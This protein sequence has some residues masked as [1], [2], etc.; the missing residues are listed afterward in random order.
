MKKRKTIII[1][2]TEQCNLN[3]SYCYER[4]KSS[5]T[6]PIET[7]KHIILD[8]MRQEPKYDS[9][10]ISLFGGE[11]FIV[12]DTIKEIVT[13]MRGQRFEQEYV[14]FVSTNGTLIHGHVQSWLVRNLDIVKIGLSL[15]GDRITHNFCRDNSFDDI[16]LDFYRNHYAKQGVKM[17]VSPNTLPHL[18]DS[19][20]FCHDIGLYSDCS[21][22]TGVDWSDAENV[23]ILERELDRLIEFYMSHLD[24]K[25]CSMLG[26]SVMS[27]SNRGAERVTHCGAGQS[28]CAYDVNGVRYPCQYFMPLAIGEEC[29]SSFL[30]MEEHQ[31]A[32][33]RATLPDA[34]KHCTVRAACNLCIG[35]NYAETGN[36]YSVNDSLCKLTK[37]IIKKR[38][39]FRKKLLEA[40]VLHLDKVQTQRLIDSIK[41]IE[42]M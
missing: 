20:V 7:I 30:R 26:R 41:L 9:Y 36:L 34:C 21:L 4:N 31:L 35:S 22:A 19:V 6:M 38:A 8:E 32:A 3:C 1:T 14:F 10:I 12:F 17:T 37:I 29:A 24:L 15:D 11:P 42:D 16:D 25:A 39:A 5:R 28:T 40:G 33:M 27:I 23:D 2:L 13:W 18:Y